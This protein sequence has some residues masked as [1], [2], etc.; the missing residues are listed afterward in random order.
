MIPV[1][2]NKEDPVTGTTSTAADPD[3]RAGTERSHRVVV[4]TD[5]SEGATRAVEWAALQAVSTGAV[6]EIVNS[7][8][9]GYAYVTPE[10]AGPM[11]RKVVDEASERAVAVAPD[12]RV[13]PKTY[14]GPADTGIQRECPGADLL[15]VGSRGRGGFAGLLLGSISR[16][17]VHTAPC[18]VVVVGQRDDDISDPHRIVVGVD[19][20]RSS[21]AAL[22]WAADQA[23]RTG[24]VLD[25]LMSWEW[26]AAVGWGPIPDDFDPEHDCRG[27]VDTMV[28]ATRKVHPELPVASVVVEGQ[29]SDVL[30]KA[31]RGADLLVVGSRGHGALGGALLGSVSAYCVSHAH[32]PIL[33]MH[34]A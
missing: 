28:E 4:G 9:P 5:G 17:C 10:D 2:M 22:R 20:S 6:L 18:P 24:A 32:S 33:V 31:S 16:R 26:V 23:E 1:A 29:A 8:G 14:W 30:V 15:V 27:V 7:F 11:M 12:V 21:E 3:P 25:V 34:G 13:L 19:G